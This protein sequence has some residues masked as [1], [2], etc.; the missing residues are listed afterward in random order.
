MSKEGTMLCL[1]IGFHFIDS[2]S[3]ELLKGLI[4]RLLKLIRETAESMKEKKKVVIKWFVFDGLPAMRAFRTRFGDKGYPHRYRD[5]VTKEIIH[6]L[7]DPPHILKRSRNE[8][9]N[10]DLTAPDGSSFSWDDLRK[11]VDLESNYGKISISRLTNTH[12]NLTSRTKMTVSL[13]SRVFTRRVI[14]AFETFFKPDHSAVRG[15]T[16]YINL[17]CD[18][19]RIFRSPEAISNV[20]D[21]RLMRLEEIEKECKEWFKKE[22]AGEGWNCLMQTDFLHNARCFPELARD[23]LLRFNV[24][25]IPVLFTQDITEEFFGAQRDGSNKAPSCVTYKVRCRKQLLMSSEPSTRNGAYSKATAATFVPR[26]PREVFA[27]QQVRATKEADS[28]E[29]VSLSTKKLYSKG[30]ELWVFNRIIGWAIVKLILRMPQEWRETLQDW[31]CQRGGLTFANEKSPIYLFAWEL[32]QL[33]NTTMNESFLQRHRGK[34]LSILQE[35]LLLGDTVPGLEEKW[36]EVC[37]NLPKSLKGKDPMLLRK[38]LTFK[39]TRALMDDFLLRKKR[40]PARNA[41][42][43]RQDP[44]QAKGDKERK[45]FQKEVKAQEE[46]DLCEAEI[47]N[48]IGPSLEEEEE[49]EEETQNDGEFQRIINS[50]LDQ[51]EEDFD[52]LNSDII[53]M[54]SISKSEEECHFEEVDEDLPT[55]TRS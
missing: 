42:A 47:Q 11:L 33:F 38:R 19:K 5:P 50:N 23:L 17:M 37:L 10:K 35:A 54:E 52:D 48:I 43:F 25:I 12:L 20:K 2:T 6:L 51:E 44:S 4:D 15:W 28:V 32:I 46:I 39:L 36:K 7:N 8:I 29:A 9:F 55:E 24:A 53:E 49:K 31:T 30:H 26:L 16:W 27:E 3:N 34:V 22:K 40:S 13:A 21:S 14:R 45:R 18:I 41:R 1:P